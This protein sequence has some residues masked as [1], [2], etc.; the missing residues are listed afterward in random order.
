[1][2]TRISLLF[3]VWLL[4]QPLTT[5]ANPTQ[6]PISFKIERPG[7]GH[8]GTNR[9][10]ILIPEAYLDGYTL[11]FDANCIGC[12]LTLVDEAENIVYTTIID[13]TGTVELPDTLS[14]TF[15]LQIVRG[16]ITFVGEIE[17]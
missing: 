2:L 7:N 16:G 9:S 17:L 11:T 5:S 14:G 12:P 8:G 4:C 13:N 6:G 3:V 15:E 1:M 10:P